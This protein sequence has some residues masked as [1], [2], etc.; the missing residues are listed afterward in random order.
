MIL[1]SSSRHNK[2]VL[3]LQSLFGRVQDTVDDVSAEENI[4][5]KVS[6]RYGSGRLIQQP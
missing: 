1:F 5:F 4:T 6:V 2:F 3:S